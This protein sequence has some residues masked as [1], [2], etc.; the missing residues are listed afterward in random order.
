MTNKIS[1]FFSSS[2]S[3]QR[4]SAPNDIYVGTLLTAKKKIIFCFLF[5]R[6]K[7]FI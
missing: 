1:F 2:F 7:H 6:A 4:R 5:L 3:A